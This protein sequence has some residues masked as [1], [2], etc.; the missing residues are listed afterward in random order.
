MSRLLLQILCIVMILDFVA[1]KN[2]ASF[3]SERKDDL[4]SLATLN[5]S[6]LA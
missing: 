3:Q 5:Q 6:S 1:L 4:Y 2:A